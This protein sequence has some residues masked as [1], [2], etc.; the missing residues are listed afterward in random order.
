M[1]EPKPATSTPL[2]AT[3]NADRFY[4]VVKSLSVFDNVEV[5]GV[6]ETLLSP[7]QEDICF[8]GTY[9]RAR[10]NIES[11]LLLQ[12]PKHFQAAAM[13]ARGLFELAVDIRL[14]EAI[15]NGSIKMIAFVDEEKLRCSRK[16]VAFKTA[17]PDVDV[18]LKPYDSFI[19]N[20]QTRVDALRKSIWPTSK[21]VR[22]WSGLRMRDR[23]ALL[24]SPFDRIYEV[25]YPSLSW[26]VHSGLMGVINLKAETFMYICA[27]S[28][29]LAADAYWEVLITVIRRFKIAKA[30][31]K[32][33]LKLK[34]AK[35][36]P[37]TDTPDQ[38]DSLM[39]MIQ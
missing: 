37:F 17:N 6:I 15:P 19:A 23:V 12:H 20:Q 3:A 18:D 11:V 9:Y 30:N 24:K 27:N 36:L 25:E 33:E 39:R 13:L 10:S 14:L 29:K 8:V 5:K 26:Y 7:T 31:E 16:I 34:V 21:S 2:E 22:H 38:V 4:T 32:I 28:F 1:A 35:M